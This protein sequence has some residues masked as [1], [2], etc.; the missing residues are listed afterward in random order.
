MII[1]CPPRRVR[2]RYGFRMRERLSLHF[3]DE[4]R[5]ARV[6]ARPFLESIQLLF[7]CS[8]A[9]FLVTECPLVL[10]HM[11]SRFRSQHP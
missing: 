3:D 7:L 10:G 6:G 9:N 1:R 11:S 8:A 5:I 2:G 4:H